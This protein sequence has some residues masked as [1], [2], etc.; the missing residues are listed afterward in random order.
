MSTATLDED[1]VRVESVFQ[2]IAQSR[3]RD[4]P[5]SNPALRV[6]LVGL[7]AWGDVRVGVL[8]TPWAMN[9]LLLPG[10]ASGDDGQRLR[11]L[12]T[13]EAQEWTFP[14]GDYPFY[15]LQEDGLGIVQMCSLF[16]PPA[17]FAT[18]DDAVL[19]AQALLLALLR[20]S[21]SSQVLADDASPQPVSR[22]ELL[23]GRLGAAG[24]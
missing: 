19:T 9:L 4:F 13:G 18:H 14:S 3:M 16:S 10:D 5:L 24:A 6:E 15:G 1:R 2:R 20:P 7:R 11:V 8:I 17:E 23:R 12:V 22:R 21:Q